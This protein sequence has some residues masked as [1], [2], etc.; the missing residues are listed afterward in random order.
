[1]HVTIGVLAYN[2]SATIARTV[3]SLF[4]QSV[5]TGCSAMLPDVHWEVLVV[6]NGCTDDTHERAVEALRRAS[7]GR[8]GAAASYRVE[9]LQR[10]GKSH[11]WNKLVHEISA[12]HTDVFVM[13]DA[14]IEFGHPDTIANC[15]SRLLTDPHAWAVVDL[16]LKDFHR[17]ADPTL[18]ER[19]SMGTSKQKLE[20]SPGIAGSFYV[21]AAP[22]LRNIWMPI[23]LSVE[24]GFLLAMLVTDCFRSDPQYSR[25]VRAD[26]ASH[27]FEGLT[28]PRAIIN[29]E[30]RLMVGTVLNAFLCWDM[31]LFLTPRDGA[32]AGVLIRELNAQD[33]D[34]YKRSMSNQ[35][36]I[37]GLWA[38]RTRYIWRQF[39]LWW[40]MPWPRRIRRLPTTLALFVFDVIVMWRAN[41]MLVSGRA[42]GY[43]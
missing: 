36:E 23:D 19:W 29:H 37:R 11:A 26:N 13:I 5:F 22:R 34:W 30:V 9:S 12:P 39:S 41:R 4:E 18:I 15:V 32:G 42:V 38:I 6:P 20:Q 40:A 14:D 1:M 43:W 8:A 28:R 7:A 10:A 31:L 17:K 33:P 24:D 21:V 25:V 35:I 16:P 27:Y 3:D 2:E